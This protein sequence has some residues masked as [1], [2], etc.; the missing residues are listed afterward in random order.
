[1]RALRPSSSREHTA[2]LPP[3]RCSPRPGDATA[4]ALE[5][6]GYRV[7]RQP[8]AVGLT[9]LWN[10][11]AAYALRAD[12]RFFALLNND[13]LVPDGAF[14][15]LTAA[16]LAPNGLRSPKPPIAACAPNAGGGSYFF[17]DF[18]GDAERKYAAS[19]LAYARVG[20]AASRARPRLSAWAEGQRGI[21]FR[22]PGWTAYCSLFD[23]AWVRD[24]AFPDGRLWNDTRWKNFG[25]EAELTKRTRTKVE[26][27]PDAAVFHFRGGTL[28]AKACQNGHR[29]C[30]TWQSG[31]RRDMRIDV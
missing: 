2:G 21:G 14:A 25:Q 24:H 27:V 26:Y 4:D 10:R 30:A 20:S 28:P 18:D 17:L 1:M 9:D 7:L 11:V 8:D 31:H 3:R 16:L 23:V 15:A 19:P 13:V 12:Y 6:A 5:A 22:L 29:D